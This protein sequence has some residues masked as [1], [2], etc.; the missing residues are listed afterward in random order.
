MVQE[1][2]PKNTR[3]KPPR[4]VMRFVLLGMLVALLAAIAAPF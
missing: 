2:Q 3:A 4:R 1:E